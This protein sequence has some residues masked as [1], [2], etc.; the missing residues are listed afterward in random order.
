MFRGGYHGSVLSFSNGIAE[1]NVDP[2]DW[3]LCQYNDVAGLRDAFIEHGDI[4][5]VIL[6]AMQGSAGAIPG[7]PEFLD[8]ARRLTSEVL[9]L[10]RQ[11][12]FYSS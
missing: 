1:N 11:L 9:K 5:A 4:A 10:C 7:K 8:A 2:S 12:W 6:E 3:I